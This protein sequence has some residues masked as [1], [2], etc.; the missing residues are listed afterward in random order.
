M[1]GGTPTKGE[2]KYFFHGRSMVGVPPAME[3]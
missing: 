2:K 3:E 1:V